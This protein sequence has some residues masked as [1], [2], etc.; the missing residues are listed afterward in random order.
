ME[1]NGKIVH[2]LNEQSGNGK[3]GVWRK[4]EY[5]LETTG[6]YPK[7]ICFVVWGEKI[8][9]FNLQQGENVQVGIEIESRE[10]NGKWYTDV[11]AWKVDKGGA[12]S[13]GSQGSGSSNTG[14]ST[15]PNDFSD[16]ST[17]TDNSEDDVLPF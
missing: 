14:H 13:Q 8:D 15:N 17:F 7:K 10:Y 2:I 4:K 11:K 9:Q 12:A 16:V 1:I 3:N 6:N 5:V